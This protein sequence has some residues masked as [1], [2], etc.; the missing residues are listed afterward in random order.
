MRAIVT[1]SSG[2]IGSNFARHLESHGWSVLSVDTVDGW[3]CRDAFDAIP[4]GFDLLVHAAAIIGSRQERE[5]NPLAVYENLALDQAAIAFA[6]RRRVPLLYF[7]S[8]AAYRTD[9][10]GPFTES[11]IEPDGIVSPD[12]AYGFIKLV[13][14]RQCGELRAEGSPVYVVRPFSGYG[15][16]QSDDYPFRAICDRVKR[17]ED[18]LDVWSDTERD[19][20]HV[21]DVVSACLAMVKRGVLGPVNIGTGIPTTMTELARM[22]AEVAGYK[23]EIRVLGQSVGPDHRY[24][25]VTAMREFYTPRVDLREGIRRALCG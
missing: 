15:T 18:P 5:E 25:D 1:G 21:D 4:A 3:D 8:S 14:E 12:A 17:R 9:R 11:D 16:D 22:A 13:G 7:S 23:P 2:F 20:I 10:P 6:L 24:A 19:F